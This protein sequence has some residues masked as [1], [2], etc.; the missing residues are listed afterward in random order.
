MVRIQAEYSRIA[1]APMSTHA[2][3]V[4]SHTLVLVHAVV[5][6][7]LANS[8]IFQGLS[9]WCRQCAVSWCL[10]IYSN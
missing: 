7:I 8:L 10:C 6:L 1:K 5:K 9:Q 4:E 3:G 2:M